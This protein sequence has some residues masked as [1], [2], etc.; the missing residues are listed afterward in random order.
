MAGSRKTL[1]N[2]KVTNSSPPQGCSG[3]KQER[4]S[5]SEEI[6]ITGYKTLS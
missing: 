1:W 4:E 5:K 6:L 2:A 3:N